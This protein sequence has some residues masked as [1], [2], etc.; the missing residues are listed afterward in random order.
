MLKNNININMEII[1]I[2][3]DK[4]LRLLLPIL[5]NSID[6]PESYESSESYES[7][8]ESSESFDSEIYNFDKELNNDDI[9]FLLN[10]IGQTYLSEKGFTDNEP[11]QFSDKVDK[12]LI[13]SFIEE[14]KEEDYYIDEL[15]DGKFNIDLDFFMKKSQISIP[16]MTIIIKYNSRFSIVCNHNEKW[17]TIDDKNSQII[18][19]RN[20]K[21]L[22]V[23]DI[24]Y[25][26]RIIAVTYGQT[27]FMIEI[28]KQE[29][30]ILKH[31]DIL[32]LKY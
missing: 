21:K 22:T 19:S 8:D 5:K 26:T 1:K 23:D 9:I 3:C 15:S 30:K 17:L 14:S 11:I 31:D 13:T 6:N 16:Y 32:I 20:N 27:N 4:N 12:N 28:N 25:A 18:L 2:K 10:T 29:F 24:L 7:L